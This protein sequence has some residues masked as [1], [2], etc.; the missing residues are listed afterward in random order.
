[1]STDM[2]I[3]FPGSF[4]DTNRQRTAKLE[5][6]WY[7]GKMQV[8]FYKSDS[9][10][11][12]AKWFDVEDIEVLMGGLLQNQEELSELIKLG[13]EAVAKGYTIENG[14]LVKPEPK[15]EPTPQPESK[16]VTGFSL[17]TPTTP[18]ASDTTPPAPPAPSK[19]ATPP[20]P[21]MS[22]KER[23]DAQRQRMGL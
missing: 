22:L 1:M 21:S 16:R 20:A 11:S 3:T 15:S 10:K 5:L 19:P 7:Y 23:M 14:K 9:A 2:F 12:K 18:T 4:T 8:G 13:T 17:S 6:R